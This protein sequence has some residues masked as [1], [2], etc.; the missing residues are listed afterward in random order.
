M[1]NIQSH[2][3]WFITGTQ[4]LYGDDALRQVAEHSNNICNIWN[5]SDYFPVKIINKGLVTNSEIFTNIVKQ[6]NFDDKCLGLVVWCHTFSPSKMWIRG[7]SILQKPYCHLHT[8]YLRNIPNDKIDM[9]YMN[10]YQSAHADREHGYIGARM[11]FARKIIAGFWQ[12]E[13]IQ[14]RLSKWIR[15]A[16]AVKVSRNLRVMRFGDNM[17]DVAVTEGDKV[18]ANIKLG[19]E[20]NTWAVGDLVQQIDSV[21]DYQLKAQIEEWEKSYENIDINNETIRYQA[22][23]ECAIEKMLDE[24][25]C[26]AFTNTFEDLWGM[27]QL[28]G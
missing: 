16:F 23:I 6:A 19:W 13:E 2:E 15:V 8:Q 22:R 21:C 14:K 4:F 28:Q 10:L 7:F 25:N 5:A 17:R 18:D 26:S 1:L 11:G 9:D 24:F 27:N 20:V 3:I 12:D